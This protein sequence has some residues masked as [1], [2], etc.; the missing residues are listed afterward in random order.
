MKLL[1]TS[2]AILFYLNSISQQSDSLTPTFLVRLLDEPVITSN[3]QHAIQAQN[4]QLVR[5]NGTTIY[6]NSQE[7]YPVEIRI[8]KSKLAEMGTI[9]LS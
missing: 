7:K 8:K 1:L 3:V 9:K 2:L 5:E 4:Y 6:S